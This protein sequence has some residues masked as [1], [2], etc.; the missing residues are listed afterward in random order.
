MSASVNPEPRRAYQVVILGGGGVGKSCLTFR[1]VH[2]QFL[3]RYDP[4]IEDSY[5]KD[6]F[7]VDGEICP[8]EIMDTAGQVRKEQIAFRGTTHT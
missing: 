1:V 4:T 5:R 3:E 6:N 8:I 7:D 2:D